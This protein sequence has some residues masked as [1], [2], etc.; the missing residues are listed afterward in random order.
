MPENEKQAAPASPALRERIHE[1][2]ETARRRGPIDMPFA[3]LVILIL[4]IGVITVLSAS[5]ATAYYETR[6][7]DAT[8]YFTRQLLFAVAGVVAM[9]ATT[10]IP[11][12]WIQELTPIGYFFA[13]ILLVLVLF[14]G[15]TRNGA[16]RWLGIGDTFTI[17][18][19]EIAKLGM[20]LMLAWMAQM[21]GKDIKSW[22]S[23][24][25]MGGVVFFPVALVALERHLSGIIILGSVGGIVMFLAGCSLPL[26]GLTLFGGGGMLYL[27]V[28]HLDYAMNRVLAWQNPEAK[29]Y[30]MNIGW[31]IRQSLYAIG[32]GGFLGA[33]IGQSRQ[34]YLYLPEESNDYI[35]SVFCEEM[36]FV[37][38]ALLLAL[39]ALLIIRGYW[40]AAHARDRYSALVMGGITT[41]MAIET[42]LNILVVTN[43][44][45]STGISL[46]FF[47]YGGTALLLQLFEM[48]IL[49]N[50][51]RD[52]P[53][54]R[55]PIRRDE[56]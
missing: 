39:F 50:L 33:G 20:I 32:S 16:K 42:I 15:Q 12:K 56:A 53:L 29:E 3:L 22:K 30:R 18:P 21:R 38:A 48:G 11:K 7:H 4:T 5:Y 23:F 17:Q 44:I 2:M 24:F 25:W 10:L 19:S 9:F 37:G 26:L 52:I 28:P 43:S 54:R 55:A 6:N 41:L 51:T 8:Y 27:A 45:P 47:S 31:Q 14:I 13:L 49:L 35:F 1:T 34:K 36:G 40:L 46:P